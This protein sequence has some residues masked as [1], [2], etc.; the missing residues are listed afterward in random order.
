MGKLWCDQ[1]GNPFQGDECHHC[2]QRR[3]SGNSGLEAG[4]KAWGGGGNTWATLDRADQSDGESWNPHPSDDEDDEA[5]G[6]PW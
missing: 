3:R 2:A 1:C 6:W 5:E 4:V